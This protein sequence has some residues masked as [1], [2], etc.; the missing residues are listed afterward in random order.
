MIAVYLVTL[1]VFDR[2]VRA[3]TRYDDDAILANATDNYRHSPDMARYI[4]NVEAG[5]YV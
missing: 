3:H 4:A 5:A 1:S 2:V